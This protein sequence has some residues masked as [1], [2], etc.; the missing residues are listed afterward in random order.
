LG[1][2]GRVLPLSPKQPM[3]PLYL[4]ISQYAFINQPDSKLRP[5]TKHFQIWFHIV[6]VLYN[7]SEVTNY[8][9]SHELI[10]QVTGF[11]LLFTLDHWY[12]VFESF[13]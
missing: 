12:I 1:A 5:L 4:I 9:S 3:S 13:A 8:I 11:I 6:S 7:E 10:L 2:C